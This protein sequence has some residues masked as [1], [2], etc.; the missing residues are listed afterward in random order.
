MIEELPQT[1][2]LLHKIFL[3]YIENF[4]IN[5]YNYYEYLYLKSSYNDMRSIK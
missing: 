5:I 4:I 2:F 3:K 1:L